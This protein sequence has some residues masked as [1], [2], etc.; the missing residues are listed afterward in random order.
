MSLPAEATVFAPSTS[1][2]DHLSILHPTTDLPALRRD[3]PLVIERG[4]GIRVWDEDGNEYIEGL[5]GLWCTSLGYGVE[6]LAEAAAEQIRKLSFA[7]LFAGRSHEPA[8]ALA[9]KLREIGPIANAK[10]FFGTSGSDANDTQVKL[11]WY[12]NNALGRPEKK[13]IISRRRG[14]HGVSVAA[15]SMTG[16]PP[17]HKSFDLPLP[18]FRHV[19]CPHYY[20]EGEPGETEAE[21]TARLAAELDELIR[22][23]GPETV[24]AF[25]AEPVLGAGGVVVP[26]EGYYPAIRKVLDEHDVLLID[27]EVICGFGRL[28]TP[29]GAEAMGMRPDTASV[30]KALSSA[31]VP[32]SAVLVPDGMVDVFVEAGERW[33]LFGHGFTYTGHP[34]CAAVALKALELMEERDLFAHAGR[35]GRYF[36]AGLRRFADHPLVG[37]VRGRGLLGACELVADKRTREAFPVQRGVGTYCMNRCLDHGVILRALGDTAAFCPPLIVTE[38]DIDEILERFGRGL[39]ETLAWVEAGGGAS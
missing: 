35:V 7:H 32:I 34:V 38:S 2:R 8:V 18:R 27:D 3:G 1:D 14:Y 9:E 31:Y 37:E 28:G 17:F 4:Q 39:D 10:A 26:P 22:A 24:A 13:K 21:F 23:E 29:F 12:Y 5:A 20:R 30:A 6:E 33:G 25:I 19:T 11:V 15:G 36:Q 16:L